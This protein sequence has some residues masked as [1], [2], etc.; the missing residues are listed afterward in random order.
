MSE[1]WPRVGIG[2]VLPPIALGLALGLACSQQPL[3]TAV[4]VAGALVVV[5]CVAQPRWLVLL[6]FLGILFDRLGLTSIR[7]ANF[8]ITASK[9]T[10]LG[11]LALWGLHVALSR[12]RLLRWH[13]VM[14]GLMG[15]ALATA[16]GIAVANSMTNGRFALFGIVMMTVLVG[17]VYTSLADVSLNGLYRVLSLALVGV[18]IL[19]LARGGGVGE[20]ARSSGTMGDPNE[21]ATMVLL[22]T[23][24]LLGGLADDRHILARGLRL[25]L[26]GLGPLAV[27]HSGSRAALVVGL[28]IL[29]A[30][31]WIL[32]K[33]G[34]ELVI[35][36]LLAVVAAP[37]LLN[38]DVALRRFDSLVMNLTGTAVVADASLDERTELF[39]QARDLFLDHWLIGVGPGNFA[40]A[41]GFVTLTGRVRPAHNTYL[42]IASEQG[43][44]GLIPT[45]VLAGIVGWTLW[46]A[47]RDAPSALHR[48][49]LV[50]ASL[51]LMGVALMAASLG[52]LT[53]SMAY[54]ALGFTLAVVAQ[55]EAARARV[56][57]VEFT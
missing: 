4:G 3:L 15:L 36:G 37:F 55:S 42:E 12:S 6:M 23:P 46:Q 2:R 11:S 57:R 24:L 39:H 25:A 52:L 22:L 45:A 14:S 5:A 48:N 21:W 10:V 56:G 40:E 29:P 9:L 16:V 30:C 34:S 28:L 1:T 31:V 53:F 43:L 17:L 41:T 18:L 54:L 35:V 7:V 51:G 38:V 26:I 49:R 44:V 33:R 20:A 32:R 19:S 47:I 50:G 27:L 13:P 8:P